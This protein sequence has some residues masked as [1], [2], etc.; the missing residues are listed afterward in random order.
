MRPGDSKVGGMPH[1]P[2]GFEWPYTRKTPLAFVAQINCAEIAH[3][4]FPARGL[5]L[6]FYDN[7][8]WGYSPNDEGFIRVV[9]CPATEDLCERHAPEVLRRRLW[10]LLGR[11]TV[12]R[13]YREARL[14]FEPGLSLPTIERGLLQFDD[15][16]VEEAYGELLEAMQG[17]RFIQIGGFPSPLQSDDMESSIAGMTGRGKAEDWAMVLQV[18]DDARTDMTWGDAGK[19]HFFCHLDD[20]RRRDFS[21]CWMELQ[22]G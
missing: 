8:G 13:V 6:F 18:Y 1:A 16:G 4:D 19:L 14:R 7:R 10:G 9:Y 3:P 17:N 15:D 5:L 22:C 12:P 2:P 21:K 20:L 11:Y